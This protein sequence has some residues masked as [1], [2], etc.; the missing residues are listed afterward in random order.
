MTMTHGLKYLMITLCCMVVYAGLGNKFALDYIGH[1]EYGNHPLWYRLGYINIAMIAHRSKFYTGFILSYTGM[2]VCGIAY[3]EKA[4]KKKTNSNTEKTDEGKE[5][6]VIM[7]YEKGTYGSIYDCELGINPKN[8]IT[9][10]NHQIHLWL[11]YN[12]FLRL[13]NV[14]HPFLKNNFTFASLMTFMA[15]ALWHG[16]YSTYYI[17]FFVMFIY[18][19]GNEVFD[20]LGFFNYIS[21]QGSYPL[22]FVVWVF[23]QFMCNSLGA[24]FFILKYDLFIQYMKNIYLIPIIFVMFI[25]IVSKLFIVKSKEKKNKPTKA[26]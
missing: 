24:I 21:E 17:F 20:K 16:L 15:S 8:K 6:E 12:L 10:W 14:D 9:S 23:S 13:I 5:R 1:I 19:T 22:K 4:I 2:I 26:D 7:N 11:K 25:Y 3:G 18:Q